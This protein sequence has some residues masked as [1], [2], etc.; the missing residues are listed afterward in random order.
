MSMKP[1]RM[2]TTNMTTFCS[3]CAHNKVEDGWNDGMRVTLI[4]SIFDVR[5]SH[6]EK[7]MYLGEVLYNGGYAFTSWI[8]IVKLFQNP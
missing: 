3:D 2:I 6:E 1:H 5:F 4:K 8:K 7:A